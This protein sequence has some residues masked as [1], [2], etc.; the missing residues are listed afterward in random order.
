MSEVTASVA[1]RKLPGPVRNCA[2]RSVYQTTAVMRM[3]LRNVIISKRTLLMILLACVPIGIAVLLRNVMPE[4]GRR[5]ASQEIFM[6]LFVVLYVYFVTI[7]TAIFYG[8]SLIGDE[9]SDHT[10]TFLLIRPV[11]RELLVLGKFLAYAVSVSVLLAA[12]LAV[13]H[14]IFAGMDYD[15]ESFRKAVP[16]LTH[17]RIIVLAAI[18]Y[19]AVFTFFGAT[20]RRPIIVA[21]AYCF[22]WESILP[23][24]PVFL[25]KGTLMHYVL[26]LI[27]NWTAEGGVLAFAAEPTKPA[28]AIQTLLWVCGAFLV[29]T[30]ISLRTKEHTFEKEKEL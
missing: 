11:P 9:R 10:I 21:F 17:A 26:S 18:A 2:L 1:D 22:V 25:K 15:V 13:T 4:E 19:G 24:L 12:S 20:F 27:P 6:G 14:W 8:T 28:Q 3:T 5:P 29:L 7:L 23:Y 30:V 16:F